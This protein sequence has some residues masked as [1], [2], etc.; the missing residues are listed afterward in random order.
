M[1]FIIYKYEWSLFTIWSR[2]MDFK[3]N[4]EKL[5][6]L[7]PF[8]DMFNHSSNVIK[9]HLYESSSGNVHI[10]AGKEYAENEQVCIYHIGF[11]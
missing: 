1:S 4:E 11:Y 2:S 10:Y 3:L 8:G 7:V 5:R 6:L 9:C